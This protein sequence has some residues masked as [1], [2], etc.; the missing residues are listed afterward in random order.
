MD[1]AREIVKKAEI[2]GIDMDLFQAERIL[3]IVMAQDMITVGD[4][5]NFLKP[6]LV[7]ERLKSACH[8]Q[9]I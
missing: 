3:G 2:C 1:T 6:P 9:Y 5:I 4:I 7:S 8:E